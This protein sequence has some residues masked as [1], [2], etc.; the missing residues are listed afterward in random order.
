MWNHRRSESSIRS[1]TTPKNAHNQCY[2]LT[3]QLLAGDNLTWFDFPYVGLDLIPLKYINAKLFAS[4]G[5]SCQLKEFETYHL[6]MYK[7]YNLSHRLIRL[8][9][10]FAQIYTL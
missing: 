7:Y 8:V 3:T 2:L 9:S 1:I 4:K 10:H 6:Y 5:P